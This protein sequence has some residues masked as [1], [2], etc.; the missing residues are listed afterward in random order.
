MNARLAEMSWPAVAQAVADGATTVI[1]PLGATEQ[2]GPHLPLGTDTFRA[3][4]LAE[5]LAA[6]LPGVLIAPALPIGCSDE[7]SGFA[8]LLSLDHATLA[9]LIVDC[10]RRMVAWGV[11]RLILLSAHGGNVRALALAAEQLAREWPSLQI[12]TPGDMTALGGALLAAAREEGITP[13]SAGLHAGEA[14]T[15][16]MLH[17]H[18]QWVS[19]DQAVPG[20]TGDMEAIMPYLQGVGLQPV[21]PSGVLGDPREATAGRGDRYLAIQAR[22]C[23]DQI[24]AGHFTVPVTTDSS[25][26]SESLPSPNLTDSLSVPRP[27]QGS[28]DEQ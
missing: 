28:G 2:H 7:H 5:R 10:A 4:A 15:S 1:W 27:P 13:E 24:E 20:Y 25:A 3:V 23:R 12:W 11:R 17:L 22:T 18:P 9:R 8:G 6:Q 14:E 19:M 16:E 26:S 21:A